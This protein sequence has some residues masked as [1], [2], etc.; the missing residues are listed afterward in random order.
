MAL[1]MNIVLIASEVAPFAK[2]GGLADVAGAL[3]R[4]LA[5]QGAAVRVVMPF[6]RCIAG[7]AQEFGL[8]RVLSGVPMDWAGSRKDFSVWESKS[9]NIAVNFVERREFFDRDGLYGTSVGDY[10]DNAERFAFFG[11][12]CLETVKALGFRPD[13]LHV[14]DWQSALALAYKKFVYA[15]DPMLAKARSLFTIHNLAYQGLFPRD[16]LARAGLPDSLFN[17]EDLEFYGRVNFL[18]AGILYSDAV[19][20]VSVG[21][22]LEIQTPEFGCGLDGLLRKRGRDL[23]GV[24]NGADYGDWNPETDA[25]IHSRYTPRDLRGKTLCRQDVLKTFGL[26]AKGRPVVGMVSRLA[27]QKGLDILV[28]GLEELFQTGLVLV[29]LGT[30][31]AAIEKALTEAAL[32]YPGQLGLKLAFDNTVAHKIYAGSDF[33]LIPSRYEPCGLTQMYALKYGTVPVVRATGGLDDTVQ[34]FDPQTQTGNGFKFK[35]YTAAEMAACVKRAL[36][37]QQ[38]KSLWR[39][40]RRNAMSCDF[41]WTRSAGEYIKLFEKMSKGA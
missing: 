6:Y 18:K 33:L 13:I 23:L 26:S 11:R 19:S 1:I 40:L 30:G 7:R 22:S 39:I 41:S 14:H 20:T 24:L 5:E 3:P 8:T 28:E 31:E 15:A 32:K 16:I 4:Y 10:P 36:A 29:I 34:E 2:T 25:H 37:V 17:M 21:Y 38:N 35:D 9:G 27:G 12:A